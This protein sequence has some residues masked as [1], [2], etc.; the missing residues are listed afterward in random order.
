[1]LSH[2]FPLYT[3]PRIPGTRAAPR[4]R[5]GQ[6]WL[7]SPGPTPARGHGEPAPILVRQGR[8]AA[9]R[10]PRGTILPLDGRASPGDGTRFLEGGTPGP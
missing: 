8:E 2:R 9:P 10:V 7:T 3:R 4:A 5:L 1:M 6:A